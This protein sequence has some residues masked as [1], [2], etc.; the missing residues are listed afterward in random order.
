MPD[1]SHYPSPYY[2]VSIKAIIRNEN[3]EVLLVREKNNNDWNLPGGGMDHG[4]DE[5]SALA[6]ELFEEVGYKGDFSYKPVGIQS[7]TL[8]TVE[9]FQLWVVYEVKPD[10]Y[11]FSVGDQANEISFVDPNLFAS[12]TKFQDRLIYKF[13][14]DPTM[15]IDPMRR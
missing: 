11:S 1:Y 15:S 7:M 10:H 13:C 14:I 12:S 6:R 9:A 3:D 4:E 8:V 2:R 5:R